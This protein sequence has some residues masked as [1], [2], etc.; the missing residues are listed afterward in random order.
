MIAD[1]TIATGDIA[2]S[3]V[4]TA[5]IATSS[6][7]ANQIG[8]NAITTAKITDLN[9]TTAKIADDAV[10]N[11]KIAADAVGTTEIADSAVTQAK[12]G[13]INT[14]GGTATRTVWDTS[15]NTKIDWYVNS[16]NHMRLDQN[17]DLN[18]NGDV[19]AY[20]TTVASDKTLKNNIS[21]IE[22]PIEKVKQ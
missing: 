22:D 18:V 11:A 20:S 9:V 21:N 6:V 16:S 14:I 2:D 10:T 19:I 4:T 17:G 8:T 3:A 5:K 1:G 7:G 13:T 12:L 15:T